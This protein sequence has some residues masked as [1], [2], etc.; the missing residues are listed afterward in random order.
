[1][2]I[3]N[4]LHV[5]VYVHIFQFEKNF[6][7]WNVMPWLQVVLFVNIVFVCV[8]E[9]ERDYMYIICPVDKRKK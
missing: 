4:L 5:H 7:T 6:K 8:I 9:A 3:D 1:M 2:V